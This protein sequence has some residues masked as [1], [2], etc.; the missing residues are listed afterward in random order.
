[1]KTT[2]SS[3]SFSVL[4]TDRVGDAVQQ[5]RGGAFSFAELVSAAGGDGTFAEVSSCSNGSSVM[6]GDGPASGRWRCSRLHPADVL[7]LVVSFWSAGVDVRRCGSAPD[8]A[9]SVIPSR[10][11]VARGEATGAAAA[12]G[13]S[14]TSVVV[15]IAAAFFHRH[16]WNWN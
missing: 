14:A 9:S 12:L 8:A 2:K 10:Q 13:R 1:M 11:N 4:L 5:E 15:N 16:D 6:S 3:K 7:V